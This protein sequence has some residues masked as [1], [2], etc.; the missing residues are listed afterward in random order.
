MA[1]RTLVGHANFIYVADCKLCVR[2]TMQFIQTE[3]GSFVTVLPQTRQ[4][5]GRFRQ[6]LHDNTPQWQDALSL[7]NTKRRD[8]TPRLFWTYDSPFLSSEGYRIIWVK[9][10]DK[11]RDDEQRRT[12]RIQ[13]TEETLTSLSSQTHGNRQKLEK[14]VRAA[15]QESQ[16]DDYFDWQI[17]GDVEQTFKQRHPGRPTATNN[18][19]P[20]TTSHRFFSRTPSESRLCS[21]STSL[22]CS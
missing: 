4:E 10:Q 18:S 21:C 8:G 22:G 2:E 20:S 1:L 17:V 16:T 11:Q 7:T 15:L 3:G 9:S 13:R 6:W 14:K 12:K 5:I 19:R